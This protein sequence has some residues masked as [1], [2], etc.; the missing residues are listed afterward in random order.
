MYGHYS[1]ILT[2]T[3]RDFGKGISDILRVKIEIL[4]CAR[5]QAAAAG[6]PA[7]GPLAEGGA[8]PY[9]VKVIAKR[10]SSAAQ[11]YVSLKS[12]RPQS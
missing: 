6:G 3:K 8:A 2:E 1:Y 5:S 4:G 10:C 9:K 7:L 12:V 11:T